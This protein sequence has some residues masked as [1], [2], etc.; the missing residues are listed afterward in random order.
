MRKPS[1]PA[2][3][4]PRASHGA[5]DQAYSADSALSSSPTWILTHSTKQEVKQKRLSGFYKLHGDS[6]EESSSTAPCSQL[7]GVSHS[8]E[9]TI[10]GDPPHVLPS[11]TH[12][13]SPLASENTSNSHETEANN[14]PSQINPANVNDTVCL[15]D[16]KPATTQLTIG[17]TSTTT[18]PLHTDSTNTSDEPGEKLTTDQIPSYTE[19]LE[20]KDSAISNVTSSQNNTDIKNHVHCT[21]VP[22]ESVESDVRTTDSI[23][24]PPGSQ[25]NSDV[26]TI[27]EQ[28]LVQER[29][30]QDDVLGRSLTT[31][32]SGTE[33][34][35]E[36]SVLQTFA[37]VQNFPPPQQ[38]SCIEQASLS[39]TEVET[40]SSVVE[41]GISDTG[42][43]NERAAM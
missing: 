25:P 43:A 32:H 28:C 33:S 3:I 31:E 42:N 21:T 19:A 22:V 36:T 15:S 11:F 6:T 12:S 4:P 16:Q 17:V 26:P 37:P 34:N 5:V 23:M 29:K 10:S 18:E 27:E 30:L 8:V 1:R 14:T 40:H 7:D 39:N 35:T 20:Q 2:P 9:D 13:T 41:H 38:I 24:S